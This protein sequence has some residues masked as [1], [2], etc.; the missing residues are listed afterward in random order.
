MERL[1]GDLYDPA[2]Q[3]SPQHINVI[4]TQIQRLQR[5]KS[6]WQ[7]GLDLLH[8]G[9]AIVRFYGALTLTIK[10]NADWDNDGLGRDEQMRNYLL[11]ALVTN[12]IRLI[13]LPDS[14]FV[15]QKL[16]S[17]LVT[18]FV[19]PDSGWTLPLRHILACMIGRHYVPEEGLPE[20][21]Q[22]LTRSN[23][24]SNHQL[25]GVLLLA[26][27]IAEDLSNRTSSTMDDSK[28]NSRVAA[29]SLDALQLLRYF[30]AFAPGS[31][32]TALANGPDHRQV[33]EESKDGRAVE[34]LHL[35]VQ[36]IP[37]W[38]NMIRYS[39][40]TETRRLEDL[41]IQCI[42]AAS[43]YLETAGM[44]GSVLQMLI[45]LEHSSAR[46]LQQALAGFPSTIVSSNMAA[47]MVTLLVR[48]DFIPD[49]LLY[50]DFLESIMNRADTTKP[51]YLHDHGLAEIVQIM[52]R[53][54]RCD[55]V[56]VIEDPVCH[57]VLQKITEIAEGS[58]DWEDVNDPAMEFLKTLTAD[59]CEACLLKIR[60]PSEQMS[61]ETQDWDVDDRARFRDFRYD[62]HDFFQ[63]AFTI[64]GNALIEEVVNTVVQQGAPPEWSTFEASTFGLIA[65]FDCI[66]SEADTYDLL[67]TTVLGSP[68]WS[69]LLQSS[70]VPDRALQTAI[71]FIAE[72]VTYLERHSDRLVPILNFLFS[73]LHLQASTTAASRAIFKLCD[74]HRVILRE[75]LPQFMGT[76]GSIGD[77]AEAERHRIFAAVAAIIQAL[78]GDEAKTEPLTQLLATIG[79]TLRSAD[80]GTV[81]KDG[82]VRVCTDIV[83]TLASIG[84]GLR[85]PAD[86]PVDLEAPTTNPSEFWTKG[87]GAHVQQEVLGIYHATLQKVQSNIDHVFVDACC[88]FIRSGFTETHPSPFKFSDSVGLDLIMEF[89]SVDNPSI[90]NAMACATSYL[91]SVSSENIPVSV[92]AVL[93]AVVSHQQHILSIHQQ[94]AQGPSSSFP[95]ASLDFLGR[96]FGKWGKLWFEIQDSQETV[97]VAM[98]LGLMVM[99][100]SDTLPR[101]SAAAFFAAFADF[102]GPE[103]GLDGDAGVRVGTVLARF[104]PR[105]LSLLLRLLGGECARSELDSLSETLK[106]YVQKQPM[107]TKAVFRAAVKE[108]A[109]VMNEKALQATTLE[110]RKR[111]VSQVEALRGARKTNEVVR[112]FW[113][114]CRGSG[115]GYIA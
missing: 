28:L 23:T 26:T 18:F 14:K 46:L 19:R 107:L 91:A 115:F 10:I 81:D 57:I 71:N 45:S 29:N 76:L 34:L 51:D 114:A 7:L 73:S 100:D 106:R 30:A 98:E 63:S 41:A 39:N 83:Q 35:A 97:A 104:G 3:S 58:T 17:T 112:D 110:Q 85:S 93:Y 13:T 56:A 78:P 113:I 21:E 88:D 16:V 40:G 108:E 1:I 33:E 62:V 2:N 6:A 36:A 54:L 12:Y 61:S 94:T 77:I 48:G 70:N 101:R 92:R 32:A 11:E 31:R 24:L 95:S 72:N 25:K 96:C 79:Q 67:I 87:P 80:D 65:L 5:E 49:A 90:D 103:T 69:Y 15:L 20:I 4:Q 68:A 42:S 27:V 8:H 43:N 55:G 84:K 44:T 74:S 75:G 99:T 50:V 52:G 102:S 111:F 9:E 109:G 59:A 53:L 82:M 37:Y 47:E 64:L 89:I 66:S 86:V 38:T 22:L 60:I 105:I